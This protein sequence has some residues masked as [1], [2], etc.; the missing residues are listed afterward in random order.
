MKNVSI[1]PLVFGPEFPNGYYK[2]I[3]ILYEDMATMEVFK[4]TLLAM[5]HRFNS[6]PMGPSSSHQSMETDRDGSQDDA[7]NEV[8]VG[9]VTRNRHVTYNCKMGTIIGLRR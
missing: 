8:L 7:I 9:E 1:G 5:Q 6:I 4:E 3:C 2:Q